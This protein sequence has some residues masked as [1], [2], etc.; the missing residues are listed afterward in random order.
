MAQLAMG[1][2]KTAFSQGRYDE[3][4]ETFREV[5]ARHPDSEAAAEAQY[6]AGVARYKATG[7]AQAL[8]DTAKS[9]RQHYVDTSSAK[10]ASV[11][12]DQPFASPP[13]SRKSIGTWRGPA[14][15]HTA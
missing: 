8:S 11:W 10:K 3:A 13:A 12:A 1:V 2:G 9:F 14:A 6:W 7:N 4:E 5:L 15:S